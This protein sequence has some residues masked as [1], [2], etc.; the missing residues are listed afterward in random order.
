MSTSGVYTSQDL[1]KTQVPTSMYVMSGNEFF[2][3]YYSRVRFAIETTLAVVSILSNGIMLLLTRGNRHRRHYS[4]FA[5][6]KNLLVANVLSTLTSWISNNMLYFFSDQMQNDMPDI[7][8]SIL[9]F[10]TANVISKVFGT[11][12]VLSLLGLSAVHCLA[13]CYPMAYV[14]Q[15]NTSRVHIAIAASWIV[16]FLFALTEIIVCSVRITKENCSEEITGTFMPLVSL[17]DTDVTIVALTVLYALIVGLCIRIAVEIRRLQGRLS[18]LC[19][20]DNLQQE[21]GTFLSIVGLSV[22]MILFIFPYHVIYFMSF[23]FNIPALS[24][25]TGVM[26]YMNLL[27]YVKYASDPV[28]FCRK[29]LVHWRVVG[30]C[31][32]VTLCQMDSTTTKEERSLIDEPVSRRNGDHVNTTTSFV[33]GSIHGRRTNSNASALVIINPEG[34]VGQTST[35]V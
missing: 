29:R 5:L 26:Y 23:N 24:M 19:W 7:C 30:C 25:N 17:V 22:T 13:V 4:Y 34:S 2:D 12:S 27:P 20:T 33:A 9:L 18:R 6:F 28:F 1:P 21:R 3:N 15:I 14:M 31:V 32:P 11:V 35:F 10:I 16:T 8:H